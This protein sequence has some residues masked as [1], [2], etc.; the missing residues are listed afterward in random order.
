VTCHQC[1]EMGHYANEI[2]ICKAPSEKGPEKS[3]GVTAT[4]EM[5]KKYM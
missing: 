1:G 2:A 3:S 4:T 5:E